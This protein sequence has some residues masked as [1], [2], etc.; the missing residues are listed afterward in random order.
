M[1]Q[2]GV[3]LKV[4]L[5]TSG[6]AKDGRLDA[7]G[8]NVNG[9]VEPYTIANP[10][11]STAGAPVGAA[12]AVREADDVAIEGNALFGPWRSVAA[13]VSVDAPSTSRVDVRGNTLHDVPRESD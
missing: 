2:E 11:T 10:P 12:V 3:G 9:I 7:G 4:V 1:V 6:P 8:V 13:A 5:G